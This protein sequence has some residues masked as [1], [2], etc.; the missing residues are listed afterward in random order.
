MLRDI[1][2]GKHLLRSPHIE[3]QTGREH[4]AAQEVGVDNV[5]NV[6]R[7]LKNEIIR[8]RTSGNYLPDNSWFWVL[9][10]AKQ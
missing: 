6:A 4:K 1:E 2:D 5:D 7:L 10:G 8:R 9:G 3:Q